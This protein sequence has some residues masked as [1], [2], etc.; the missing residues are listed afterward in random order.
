[1]YGLNEASRQW[2]NRVNDELIKLGMKRCK[3][4]EALFYLHVKN[5]LVGIITVHVDDFLYGGTDQ[6][7]KIIVLPLQ[8]IFEIGRICSTPMIYLG[9]LIDQTES[10]IIVNQDQYIQSLEEVDIKDAKDSE[11]MLKSA[12]HKEY[13]RIC[14]RLNW[15]STQTRPDIAFDVAMIS[16]NVNAP[17][18]KHLKLANKIVRK[19]KSTSVE[20]AFCKLENPLH[21]SVYCDAS[22]GNLPSGG[23]QGG[24]IVFLSDENGSLS[25]LSWTSRKVRRV[26]RS[27]ISSETM[28]ML[29]AVDMSIWIMHILKDITGNQPKGAKLK[30]DS[31]SLYDAAHSTTA[32]E[33]KRL[34]VDIAAIREEIRKRSITVDWIPKSEQL[35]DVLTKQGANRDCLLTVLRNSHL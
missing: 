15:I 24:Q 30:T 8:R 20:I 2:Y 28:S 31:K 11:R 21:L 35:A 34:R 27:T 19:V 6:F 4:D 18:I 26:C 1:M 9:L 23:S 7:H 17:T 12:E 25:P 32:V 3:Y 14:G 22:Y 13:R 29:D 10:K 5:I 16:A 33:E